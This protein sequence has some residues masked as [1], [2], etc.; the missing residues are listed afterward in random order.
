MTCHAQLSHIALNTL[1]CNACM[2]HATH[3]STMLVCAQFCVLFFFD[4][5]RMQVKGCKAP[6]QHAHANTVHQAT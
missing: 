4:A 2:Q 3:V 5:L 1:S 6:V